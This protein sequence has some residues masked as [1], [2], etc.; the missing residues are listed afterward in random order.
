MWESFRR[1]LP[2][3]YGR[4]TFIS[5]LMMLVS[6]VFLGYKI[7]TKPLWNE[8][9]QFI[10]S[11]HTMYKV[12]KIQIHKNINP[13]K[14]RAHSSQ[15]GARKKGQVMRECSLLHSRFQCRHATLHPTKW[16][17]SRLAGVVQISKRW[18]HNRHNREQ[19]TSDRAAHTPFVGV[20]P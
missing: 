5:S 20:T 4:C 17:C 13:A 14:V 3:V 8:F 10:Q 11:N 18:G 15:P 9:G 6:S 2:T 16:L 12:R 7:M 19:R 1:V